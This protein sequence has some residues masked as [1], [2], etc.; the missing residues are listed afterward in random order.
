[1]AVQQ[2]EYR[3]VAGVRTALADR[4]DGPPV[5][6]VHGVPDSLDEWAPFLDR[7]GELGRVIAPDMPG[8]GRSGRPGR[9]DFATLK[10]WFTA[11]IDDL[12]LERYRLVVHDWGAVALAAAALRPEQ[13]ERLVVIDA[14]ALNPHY[15]WHWLA[16]AWRTPVLGELAT[17]GMRRPTL[18]LLTH[19]SSPR[20]GPMS[21]EF[22]DDA[23]RYLD[24]GTR[25]AI[26]GL[27]R[28]ADA[29]VLGAA[30]NTLD[31]VRC[32]ALVLWGDGD[33]YLNIREAY[34]FGSA[35]PN[36]EVEIVRNAGHWCFRE[37]PAVVDRVIKFLGQ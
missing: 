37:D 11:L 29:G 13:V 23:T 4:G 6:F 34:R 17:I 35:L 19:L 30:G 20:P 26:L 25:R 1:M 14:V 27:Y 36:S 12:G 3:D 16:R 31:E 2:V 24:S 28:S 32:P 15:R 22:L 5:I 33:P 10:M 8:F 9:V 7:A 18:K 21:D